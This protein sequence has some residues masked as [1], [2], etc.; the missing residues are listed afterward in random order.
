VRIRSQ[1]V[2]PEGCGDLQVSLQAGGT[3]TPDQDYTALPS[4]IILPAGSQFTDVAITARTDQASE[5]DESLSLTLVPETG[6]ILVAPTTATLQIRDADQPV[7]PTLVS[8]SSSQSTLDEAR[9]GTVLLALTRTQGDL[10]VPLTVQLQL[11]GTATAGQDYQLDNTAITFDANSQT[12]FTALIIRDDNHLESDETLQLGIVAGDG[13]QPGPASQINL[14][15]RDDESLANS[16]N[17]DQS[18]PLNQ[19]TVPQTGAV[20][21]SATA[22][23]AST[24]AT[25]GTAAIPTLQEWLL[26]L[27]GLLLSLLALP[28]LPHGQRITVPPHT[29]PG[30]GGHS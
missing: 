13:Y 1:T 3:A 26:I 10:S 9:S 19:V 14:L 25:P 18:Q 6:Y 7:L 22:T 30:G 24:T 27:L 8:I 5:V 20:T 12:T 17:T 21:A 15:I 16:R 29:T 23:T 28:A 4:S 2:L 11:D